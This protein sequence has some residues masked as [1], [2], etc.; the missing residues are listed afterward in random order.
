MAEP[1]AV[2]AAAAPER[3][4]M[5]A[6]KLQHPNTVD[7]YDFGRTRA[8]QPYCVMECLGGVA[9]AE[10]GAHSGLVPQGRANH[11]LRQ[12]AS[13][14]DCSAKEMRGQMSDPPSASTSRRTS[15][16]A[17]KQAPRPGSSYRQRINARPRSQRLSRWRL[18]VR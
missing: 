4:P 6:S 13:A 14:A 16:S 7:V 3:V 15:W 17:G 1:P 10:L 12:V 5:L 9:L 8:G 18:K 2:F 11:I